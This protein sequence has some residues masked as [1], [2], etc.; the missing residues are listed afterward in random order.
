M[1]MLLAWVI[2]PPSVAGPELIGWLGVGISSAVPSSAA[3]TTSS[4]TKP[5]V[6]RVKR[7]VVTD[8]VAMGVVKSMASTSAAPERVSIAIGRR[9]EPTPGSMTP[10]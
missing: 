1:A 2:V 10:R 6:A 5:V 3:E 4:I 7:L 8:T 9:S